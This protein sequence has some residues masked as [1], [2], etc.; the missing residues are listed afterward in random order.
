M[1]H[2]I[3]RHER[4]KILQDIST[5]IERSLYFFAQDKHEYTAV[6][7]AWFMKRKRVIHEELKALQISHIKMLINELEVI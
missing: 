2:T 1:K 7:R 5:E 6:Q 4:V 3:R